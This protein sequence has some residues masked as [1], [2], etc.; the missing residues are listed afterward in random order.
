MFERVSVAPAD[1][2]LGLN[3]AYKA[4][5]RADKINL[6]VGVFKDEQGNTPILKAV[7]EAERRLVNSETS[8]GYLSIDGSPEYSQAVQKLLLGEGSPLLTSGRVCT[9]QAPGG[10]GALRIGA[11]FLV[12]QLGIRTIWVSDPTWANHNAI[13]EAAG[14]EVKTYRYFDRDTRGLDI[15]GMLA[16]IAQ[17]GPEHAVVLHG[18]CHNP[19]GVDPTIAQ[20]QRI[21]EVLENTGA[22]AFFDFAYQGFGDGLE[23]DAAGLR[24]LVD[25]LSDVLIANSFSKNFGLYNERVGALTAVS[26]TENSAQA[27]LSQLKVLIRAIYSNPPCHGAAVV[28]TILNDPDLT[29]MWHD[30]LAA[31]RQRINGLRTEFVD[32]L[33]AQGASRDFSFIAEQRGM[34]SFSGLNKDQ[35]EELREKHGIYMVGSGRIN[36]AGIRTENLE[37]LCR[38]IADVL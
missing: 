19:S 34:F 26:A 38:A 6:G 32:G 31:M 27:V 15:D 20:W 8:K 10:T 28:S 1:P 7:K 29:A 13:F 17:A 11:E 33:K 3:D 2:I 18:C 36:I 25:R 21:G 22:T 24:M 37:K 9:T 4:D 30:E 14:L 23:E 35:V 5:P 16:D 12:R